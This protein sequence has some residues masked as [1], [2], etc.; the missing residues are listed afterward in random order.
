MLMFRFFL[1]ADCTF[2]I[3][4]FVSLCRNLFRIAVATLTC[5]GLLTFVY[6]S[7]L[8][9]YFFGVLMLMFIY[10]IFV[11][12]LIDRLVAYII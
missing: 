7:R 9:G 11:S 5:K 8:F 6:A 2:T 3:Y 1:M 10:I 4:K 12:C